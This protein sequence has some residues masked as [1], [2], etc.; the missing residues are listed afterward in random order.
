MLIGF[1]SKSGVEIFYLATR[2]KY[3]SHTSLIIS[4]YLATDD[5]TYTYINSDQIPII[6]TFNVLSNYARDVWSINM[7]EI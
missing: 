4:T 5:L 1:T 3:M 2:Q 7:S 6:L